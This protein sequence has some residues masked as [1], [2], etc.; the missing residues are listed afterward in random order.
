ME[1]GNETSLVSEPT[2]THGGQ[3]S[4]LFIFDSSHSSHNHNYS[5]SMY[6]DCS[7]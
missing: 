2:S 6:Q 1:V 7:S 4:L 5:Y 3:S